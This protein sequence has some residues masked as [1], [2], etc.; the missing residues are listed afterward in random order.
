MIAINQQVRPAVSSDGRQIADLMFF[1]SQVHKHLDYRAPLEWL[2]SPHYWVME[3]HGHLVAALACPQDPPGIAWIRLFGHN[4]LLSGLEAWL[5]LWEAARTEIQAAGGACVAAIALKEWFQDILLASNFKAQQ[6]I[7]LLESTDRSISP[8]L[9]PQGFLLRPMSMDDLPV[10]AEV[11]ADAFDLLWRNSATA[12]QKALAQAVYATVVVE[13][14]PV[15]E[16]AGRI[17]G[18]QISTGNPF[19]AHL[20]RLAVRHAVQGRGIGELLISD[21]MHWLQVRG[22]S[23]LSVN[24]QAD[25]V[26]SLRLYEKMGFVRTGELYP[27]F[28]YQI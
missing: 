21:L 25:N 2:G 23:R 1:G 8:R 11:D 24:T 10:V 27:V 28:V 15:G 7:L 13:A 17:V 9:L 3:E 16:Q 18:Y 22:L 14:L 5:P 26:A 12:L 4:A 19:G 20:G 6:S